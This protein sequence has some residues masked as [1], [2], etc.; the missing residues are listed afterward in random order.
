MA[1]MGN[2][3]QVTRTRGARRPAPMGSRFHEIPVPEFQNEHAP[4]ESRA[5]AASLDVFV[6][7]TLDRAGFEVASLT[8]TAL[9]QDT[10]EL[11]LGFAAHP[12]H[13]GQLKPLLLA[14]DDL[15]WNSD[16]LGEFLEDVF[17]FPG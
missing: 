3:R 7:E 4:E 13:Q 9:E 12:F 16:A 6:D 15:G 1:D 11:R 10:P 8:G 2:A 17:A 5:V 14:V